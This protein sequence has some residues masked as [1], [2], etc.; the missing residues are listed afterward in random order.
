[1]HNI[2]FEWEFVDQQGST[3]TFRAK[4]IGGWL[5][6]IHDHE[7]MNTVFIKDITHEWQL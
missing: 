4:V 1:M 5:V 6:K 2:P 3:H 7:Q